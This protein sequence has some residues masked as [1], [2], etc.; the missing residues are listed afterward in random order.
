MNFFLVIFFG[1]VIL[2]ALR[3]EKKVIG[4]PS[5]PLLLVTAFNLA[6]LALYFITA[7]SLGF[8][9][10]VIET[11][12]VLLYGC[13]LFSLVS[14]VSTVNLRSYVRGHQQIKLQY[15]SDCPNRGVVVFAFI[16]IIYMV[17]RMMAIGINNIIEDEDSAALFGAGG[18]SGHILVLQI[19]L[20][21]HLIGRKLTISSM[22]AI[23]GLVFCL[24]IYNVKAWVIIPFLLGW[25][26]RRDLMGMKMNPIVLILV[27]V[28]SF[29]IF[30]VSYM[31]TLGWDSDNMNFIWAHF[32]KYIYAGIGGLNE[33]LSHNYPIGQA[34]FYGTPSFIR[35]FFPV[36]IKTSGVY[37]YVVIN[38]VNG[39]YTNVFSL[40][41]GAYLF[42]GPF[43]GSMYI[44]I[45]AVISYL[46]YKKR[47]K[48]RNYWF[49][50]S[51]YF[52]SAGLILSFFGN[53][54]TLL[55]I[56]ELTVEAFLVGFWYRNINI[57][58]STGKL[59]QSL[60]A[61]L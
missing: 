36:D 33:A 17:L 49:Y 37:D 51:Y 15:V 22:S 41:G 56:W 60:N 35:L 5:S 52:W 38:D 18:L 6:I 2:L 16:T 12:V 14:F 50:L 11:L 32:C 58:K 9:P 19:F 46:L 57:K 10:L 59:V 47:L 20:A 54:Y 24:F 13:F 55:N 40:F 29:A 28:G 31:M 48:T 7:K 25:F 45:I 39:E 44:L 1:T 42:N 8:H 26:I 23:C 61:N 34:P 30:V 53:Y 27:P 43:I 3:R 21:T 4:A